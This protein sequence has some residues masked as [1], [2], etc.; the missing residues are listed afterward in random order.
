MR[1]CAWRTAAVAWSKLRAR[2]VEFQ[3]RVAMIQ[4]ADHLALLH[5]VAHVDRR[6]DHQPRN[7]WAMSED[8]SATN[9]PVS[10]NP[11]DTWRKLAVAVET[12]T[13]FGPEAAAT[14]L[15]GFEPHAASNSIAAKRSEVM[16]F[17]WVSS[18]SF[19][20]PRPS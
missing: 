19:R 8:S 7:R 3:L 18:A 5:E 11:A 12:A 16:S 13:A 10:A 6:R 17:I 20:E 4:F 9:D 15:A 1:D 14:S 2:L